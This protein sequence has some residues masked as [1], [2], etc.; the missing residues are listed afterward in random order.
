M[1]QNHTEGNAE[2]T[3]EFMLAQQ[4]MKPQLILVQGDS[5][6]IHLLNFA[7]LEVLL[8]VYSLHT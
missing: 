8:K 1:V 2:T 7:L 4:N 5:P 6:L 3:Y